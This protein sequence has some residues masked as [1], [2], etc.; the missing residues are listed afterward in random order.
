MTALY[1]ILSPEQASRELNVDDLRYQRPRS[2]EMR[3]SQEDGPGE[4]ATVK[5][6]YK[7]P[8]GKTSR[9]LEVPV[10][11]DVLAPRQTSDAFRFS[12]AVASFGMLLRD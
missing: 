4:L 8:Q 11:A 3:R 12:A 9:L 5:L 1:E 7:A 2:L 6:R 10:F